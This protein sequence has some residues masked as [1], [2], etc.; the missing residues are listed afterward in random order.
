[1]LLLSLKSRMQLQRGYA[2]GFCWHRYSWDGVENWGPP[3]GDWD[4]ADWQKLFQEH[5]PAGTCFFGVP[6]YLKNRWL[7][8]LGDDIQVEEN[9]DS[10]EYLIKTDS[11]KNLTGGQ[12]E[13][14]RWESNRFVK[15]YPYEIEEIKPRLFDE[16][17]AFH[18]TFTEELLSRVEDPVFAGNYEDML[19]YVLNHWQE[20]DRLYGFV[21]RVDGRIAAYMLDEQVDE[22]SCIGLLAAADYTYR[23]INQFAYRLNAMRLA[24]RGIDMLNISDDQGEEGLRF[25]KQNLHPFAMLKKYTVTYMPSAARTMLLFSRIKHPTCII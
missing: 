2:D 12:F 7:Q 25:F 3:I 22:T 13:N 19:S 11:L 10:W 5:V 9:R 14:F 20:M 1:M 21:I 16:L 18:K 15:R 4:S 17:L 24:E 8:A 23:G 6:E